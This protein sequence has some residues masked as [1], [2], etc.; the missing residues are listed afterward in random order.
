[1]VG[2]DREGAESPSASNQPPESLPEQVEVEV[3]GEGVYYVTFDADGEKHPADDL[4][5]I[6]L[7]ERGAVGVHVTGE[8]PDEMVGRRVYSADL[9]GVEPGD[10]IRADLAD[11]GAFRNRSQ[12]GSMGGREAASVY[13][14]SRRLTGGADSAGGARKTVSGV[15]SRSDVE[16]AGGNNRGGRSA[17]DDEI[18]IESID[19]LKTAGGGGEGGNFIE[20]DRGSSE[21]VPGRGEA[22]D[23]ER[24][25]YYPVVVYGA[26]WCKVCRKAKSWLDTHEI[27]YQWRDI[28]ESEQATEDMNRFC[29]QKGVKPGAIPTIRI[30]REDKAGAD[31]VMQGWSASTFR[32]LASR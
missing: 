7:A 1:M 11:F 10:R 23:R 24:E 13:T 31:K 20:V 25:G 14:K 15:E 3:D 6:P 22:D 17:G 4:G 5:G 30:I 28:E 9:F 27:S 19:D 16:T 8:M 29:R 18:V 21:S 2:C 26:D 32:R 12:A